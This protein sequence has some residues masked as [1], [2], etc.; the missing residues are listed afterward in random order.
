VISDSGRP[1]R[2]VFHPE[3][4]NPAHAGIYSVSPDDELLQLQLADE[5]WSQFYTKD[6]IDALPLSDCASSKDVM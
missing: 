3:D 6:D 4:D 1:G 2:A 5:T